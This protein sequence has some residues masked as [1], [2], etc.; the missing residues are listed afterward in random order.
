MTT[1]PIHT[2]DRDLPPLSL[3]PGALA[4]T[5][6]RHRYDVG[7]EPPAIEQ[8][9]HRIRL[10]F[11]AGGPIR[12]AHLLDKHNPWTTDP[13]ESGP[14]PWRFFSVSRNTAVE[15]RSESGTS[16]VAA[17]HSYE[18][19]YPA[20]LRY[21]MSPANVSVLADQPADRRICRVRSCRLV[22]SSR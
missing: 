3:P 1:R 21:R 20:M 18:G 9:E 4:K 13:G 10:D 11:M 16:E 17:S 22:L 8:I 19:R 15:E 14:D 5:D 7:D 12:R 6:Q 2:S